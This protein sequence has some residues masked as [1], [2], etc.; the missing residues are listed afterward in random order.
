MIVLQKHV[1]QI[2]CICMYYIFIEGV[3]H[4]ADAPKQIRLTD[5]TFEQFKKI[6]SD[7]GLTAQQ[8]MDN[9]LLAYETGIAREE[10]P[11][12]RTDL[13][14]FI[15]H[16]N[17]I[18]ESYLHMI[19]LNKDSEDR[20]K[21]EFIKKLESKDKTIQNLQEQKAE[22]DAAIETRQEDIDRLMKLIDILKDDKIK[23]ESTI[24]SLNSQLDD[25]QNIITSLK[26]ENSDLQ[27]LRE[28][29]KKNLSVIESL[30]ANLETANKTITTINLDLQE[31]KAALE[32]EKNNAAIAND[33]AELEKQI[34]VNQIKAEYQDKLE[35]LRENKGRMLEEIAKLKDYIREIDQPKE[36]TPEPEINPDQLSFE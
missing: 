31:Q 7:N 35:Q 6:A 21:L 33:K 18:Q 29:N 15:T 30:K 24:N 19:Q 27:E 5:E 1:L 28:Q 23:D 34:A 13:D 10:T 4:M 17:A 25:K 36:V 22:A 14:N 9:L 3:L 11:D 20:A 16:L 12:T 2:Q 8:T 26:K 32:R